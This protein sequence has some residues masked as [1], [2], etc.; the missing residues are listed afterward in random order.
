M[1]GVFRQ[2]QIRGRGRGAHLSR[3]HGFAHGLGVPPSGPALPSPRREPDLCLF[4]GD[5]RQSRGIG[6]RLDRAGH[7]RGTGGHGRQPAETHAAPGRRGRGRPEGHRAPAGSAGAG[8]ADHRVL[9]VAAHDR[10]HRLVG[11]GA[12]ERGTGAHLRLSG[13]V[14]AGGAARDRGPAFVG[15]PAGR[16]FDQRPGAWHRHRRPR[17]VHPGRLSRFHHGHVAAFRSR[18]SRRAG[19][20]NVSCRP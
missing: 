11:R 17:C 6:L 10:T 9:Q 15:R 7:Q 5:H 18:R 13:R 4:L 20:G 1:G 16:G 14:F 2:S 8:P 3:S 19:G 12:R